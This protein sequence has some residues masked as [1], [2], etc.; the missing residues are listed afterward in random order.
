MTWTVTYLIQAE[1]MNN[2]TTPVSFSIIVCLFAA[3]KTSLDCIISWFNERRFVDHKVLLL[4]LC[5]LVKKIL[6]AN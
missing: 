3:F 4:F 6:D 5:D 2:W 1:V